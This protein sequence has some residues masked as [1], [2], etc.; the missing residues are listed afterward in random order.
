MRWIRSTTSKSYT[1]LGLTIPAYTQEPLQVEEAV[2]NKLMAMPVLKSL[3]ASGGIVVLDAY[4]SPKA[5]ADAQLTK[6]QSLTEENAKLADKVRELEQTSE[7]DKLKEAKAKFK[8]E[9]EALE[10]QLEA[11]KAQLEEQK[12]LYAELEKEAQEKLAALT[13]KE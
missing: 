2:H 5:M 7:S 12:K 6:L 3:L 4:T 11:Q 1:A 10:A 8:A 9:K 13:N